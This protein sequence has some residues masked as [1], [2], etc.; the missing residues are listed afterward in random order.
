MCNKFYP[1]SFCLCLYKNQSNFL[2]LDL[3]TPYLELLNTVVRTQY[4][5]FSNSNRTWIVANFNEQFYKGRDK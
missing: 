3:L 5:R 1:S 4:S 2:S